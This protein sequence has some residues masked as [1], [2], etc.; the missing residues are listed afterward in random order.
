MAREITAPPYNLGWHYAAAV[1]ASF[2]P[3]SRS[4]KPANFYLE[5]QVA[6]ASRLRNPQPPMRRSFRRLVAIN[7]RAPQRQREHGD[8]CQLTPSK[9]HRKCCAARIVANS[10]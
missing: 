8:N 5:L 3:N 1:N 6:A 10:S 2:S 7:V 4:S 9:P